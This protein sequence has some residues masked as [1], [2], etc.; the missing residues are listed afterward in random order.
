MSENQEM[1]PKMSPPEAGK[2]LEE[3]L[4]DGI[5]QEES[6]DGGVE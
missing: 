3:H 4:Q 5:S 6:T 1:L 2:F